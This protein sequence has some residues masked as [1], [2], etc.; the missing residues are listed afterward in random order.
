[1][2]DEVQEESLQRIIPSTSNNE[3]KP[4]FIET[5]QKDESLKKCYQQHNTDNRNASNA[6]WRVTVNQAIVLFYIVLSA[7]LLSYGVSD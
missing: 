3:R 1:M 4:Q 6:K 7:M 5:Q 2:Q